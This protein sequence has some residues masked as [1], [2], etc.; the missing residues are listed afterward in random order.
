MLRLFNTICYQLQQAGA[1]LSIQY[2][3]VYSVLQGS[4]SALF[5]VLE[6][7][8]N[9]FQIFAVVNSLMVIIGF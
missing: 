4:S 1:S 6:E 3:S 9:I 8:L 2:I 5:A 7:I